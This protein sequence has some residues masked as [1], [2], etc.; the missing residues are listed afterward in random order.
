[1]LGLR[2]SENI[3]TYENGSE[4]SR[5]KGYRTKA[6]VHLVKN[7]ESGLVKK[8]K[9]ECSTD[10]QNNRKDVH[11]EEETAGGSQQPKPEGF[12]PLKV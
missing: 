7:T 8:P 3:T 11:K 9:T 12:G 10:L 5:N 2:L 1:L 4:K 6:H